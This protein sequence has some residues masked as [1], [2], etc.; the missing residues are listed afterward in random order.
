MTTQQQQQQQ[1][2]QQDNHHHDHH[3]DQKKEDEENSIRPPNPKEGL[4]LMYVKV[5]TDEQMELLRHQISV[6]ASIC[7]KLADMF[8]SISS[9]HDLAGFSL[10][11]LSH[12]PLKKYIYI[13][14]H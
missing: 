2:Q 3:D 7:E 5:M 14:I 8:N 10:L 13:Y 1:Q 4:G 12:S 6:Y 9:Q 11:S